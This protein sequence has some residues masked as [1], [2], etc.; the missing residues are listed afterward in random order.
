MRCILPRADYSMLNAT[1]WNIYSAQLRVTAVC[2]A[3]KK[4][5]KC[6][7][8]WIRM[9]NCTYNEQ[10]GV[11][12]KFELFRKLLKV[13]TTSFGWQCWEHITKVITDFVNRNTGRR[14][15]KRHV[16]K[17]H[18]KRHLR[19]VGLWCNL[20][21]S[22]VLRHPQGKYIRVKYAPILR[23]LTGR[24]RSG[25][26]LTIW[27]PQLNKIHTAVVPSLPTESNLILDGT[28]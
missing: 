13:D 8:T 21:A 22:I 24:N 16:Y 7:L 17:K 1:K 10:Y 28:P 23:Q 4:V 6:C 27:I 26:F 11:L 14:S 2:G 9:C 12:W 5:Q 25:S 20:G 19:D 15:P 18:R 3:Q